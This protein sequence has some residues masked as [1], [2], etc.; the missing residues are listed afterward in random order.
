[1][2]IP[3]SVVVAYEAAHIGAAADAGMDG[4]CH[5]ICFNRA[6]EDDHVVV[7]AEGAPAPT[8]RPSWSTGHVGF[9]IA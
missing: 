5:A 6:Y 3:L 4:G 1:M 8:Q 7:A 2:C 9:T